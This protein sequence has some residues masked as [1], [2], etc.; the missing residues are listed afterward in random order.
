MPV[1]D[2]NDTEPNICGSTHL[3]SHSSNCQ[4]RGF[5]FIQKIAFVTYLQNT[6]QSTF[7]FLLSQIIM[8]IKARI[9]SMV[10]GNFLLVSVMG[11]FLI[12]A[13]ITG[14]MTRGL[15]PGVV[16]LLGGLPPTGLCLQEGGQRQDRRPQVRSTGRWYASYWN[17][18]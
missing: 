2:F 1:K 17:A 7:L 18:R 8:I 9:Q 11:V 12:P 16:G 4:F 6:I 14:H 3:S 13:C 5:L 10:Q 15:P